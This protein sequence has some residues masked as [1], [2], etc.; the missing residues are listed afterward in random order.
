MKLRFPH[1]YVI[2]FSLIIIAA[3]LTWIFPGGDYVEQVKMVD[4]KEVKELVFQPLESQPQT[5]QVFG[6]MFKGFVRQAGIIVLI[7]MIGGAFWIMNTTKALDTGIL[8]FINFTRGLER[9]RFFKLVGVD[10][11]VIVLIMLMFSLFGAIFGMSEESIAF[12]I[13]LVPLAISMGYDSI[14]GVAMCYLAAHIGFAAAMLNPFTIGIAQG[15]AGLP[16]FS[17]LEYRFFCFIIINIV[18]IGFVLWYAR[19][20]KKNPKKSPVHD[21]DVYWRDKAAGNTDRIERHT[22][23]SAWISYGLTLAALIVFSVFYPMTEIK[24]GN[25]SAIIIPAIPV[26]TALFALLGLISLRKTVHYFILTLLLFTIV[27]LVIGVMGYSWYIMEIAALF[28]VMGIASGIAMGYGGN[29]QVKLFLDGVRDIVSAALVVGLAGGIIVILEDGKV[30]DTILYRLASSLHQVG[31][32]QAVGTMYVIQT[33]INLVI[34]SG[35][36]KAALTM[37]IMAPFSDLINL[38]RQ[39][40]VMAF[41]FGD[42]F[43]NMI[44][45]TSGVLIGALGV[46]KIPY[47]KWFRWVWPLILILFI[48]GFSLLIPTVTMKLNGF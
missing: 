35:S 29:L 21:I 5:W 32:I 3:I 39:A 31:Q 20:I 47:D 17:G 37:P 33:V 24:I 34:P 4:G 28:F 2:I 18:G 11:V 30:I 10:N 12:V 43:T 44:T 27:F 19:R 22:P 40:T 9:F 16:L 48:L 36:A 23:V 46:A 1:T 26:A 13:I 6:S 25:S 7:L 38:S 8:S 42:G 45:P 41:Q 14:V 15:I